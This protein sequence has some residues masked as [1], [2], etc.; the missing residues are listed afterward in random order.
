MKP[1]EIL[2]KALSIIED[3]TRWTCGAGARNPTELI[4]N[5]N[6]GEPVPCNDWSACKWCWEGAVAHVLEL[7]EWTDVEF[8][9]PEVH[10]IMVEAIYGATGRSGWQPWEVNDELGYETTLEAARLAVKLAE[11]HERNEHSTD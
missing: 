10:R 2:S 11:E 7:G 5:L 8:H 4:K 1:S 9:F 6:R 3:E